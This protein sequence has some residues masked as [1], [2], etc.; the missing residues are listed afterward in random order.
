MAL[1]GRR[2]LNGFAC[3]ES[4]YALSIQRIWK[5][6]MDSD[7]SFVCKGHDSRALHGFKKLYL[8]ERLNFM[9]CERL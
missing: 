2:R 7:H 5:R 8:E 4:E 6:P 3:L 9:S 1:V